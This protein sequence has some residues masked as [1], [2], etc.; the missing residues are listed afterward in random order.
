MSNDLNFPN[1]LHLLHAWQCGDKEA[2]QRLR[3]IYEEAVN[4]SYDALFA[5]P[6]PS[7]RVHVCGPVDLLAL[8][9]MFRLYGITS[10]AFYKEDAERFIRCSLITQRLMGMP[11]QYISW[12]VYGFTAEA[13][14]QTMIYSDQY[15]PGTDPDDALF[16]QENWRQVTTPALGSG[17][18]KLIAE[19]CDSY[20]R[21]TKQPPVLHLSAPYSLAADVF[22]QEAIVKAL[23]DDADFVA[24]FLDL[25][26]ERVLSPWI[27]Q[28]F[29]AYPEGWVELSDASGSPLFI[30]PENCT[31]IAIAAS[32]RLRQSH[33]L[34]T[35]IYDANYRGDYVTRAQENQSR[36]SRRRS[37]A[38]ATSTTPSLQALFKA[39]DS[40]CPDYVIRLAEDRIDISFYEEMAIQENKPLFLGIG[41]TQ[42][43]RNSIADFESQNEQTREFSREYTLAVKRVAQTIAQNGY[44]NRSSPWPGNLYFED[45]SAE[46][47]FKLIETIFSNVFEHG[48]I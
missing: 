32:Q 23:I 2:E 25:L 35:R 8:T 6:P 15:S 46:S 26:A 24:A 29:A 14:G 28:F 21:L 17:I 36:R 16:N 12:P 43:D 39:K 47:S 27:G 48:A 38:K 7:D 40:V 44:E 3:A 42:V 22:G 20:H 13:M 41:A 18:P 1:G 33:P 31:N 5:T 45:I 37:P 34:G 30:G 4:G 11:K 10:E 19:Y 9:I